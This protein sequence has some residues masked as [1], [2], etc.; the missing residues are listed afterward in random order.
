MKLDTR[1]RFTL[2]IPTSLFLLLQEDANRTGHSV[3]ALILQ[4]LWKWMQDNQDKD[5]G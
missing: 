5:A 3:N 2:R 4:I 1:N